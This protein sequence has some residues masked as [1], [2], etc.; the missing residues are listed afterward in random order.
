MTAANLVDSATHAP[1]WW[2]NGGRYVAGRKLGQGASAETF[3]ARE[4]TSHEEVVLKLFPPGARGA[5]LEFRHL[6][7]AAHP[8]I[9][10]VR[11]IGR[12]A[13]GRTF[14]VTDFVPGPEIDRI[15]SIASDAERRRAF[16]RAAAEL[17]D[18]LAHLHGRGVMHGDICPAN[19]RLAA[20]GRAVLLD[21]GLAGPPTPGTG[22]A[23]GTLGYAAPEALTGAR[24]AVADLFALGA[25]LFASWTGAPPFGA[26]VAAVQRMLTGRAPTLSSVRAGLPVAW[27][28]LLERLLAPD[29]RDRP[30][31]AR[32]L[33]REIGRAVAN[34]ETPTEVDLGVPYPAGDPLEGV[35]VGRA[36]EREALRR[37]LERLADGEAA[38]AVIALVGAPGS[39]RRTLVEAVARDVDVAVAAGVLPDV[40]ILRGD[41]EQIE[42]LLGGAS[43]GAGLG[44]ED[45]GR[46]LQRRLADL[47]EALERRAAARPIAVI[48]PEGPT[49]EALAAMLA[50]T[51]PSGRLLLVIPARAPVERPFAAEIALAPL[52]SPD[53]ER[54]VAQALPEGGA[55]A[56]AVAAIVT[57]SRGHAAVVGVLAR[58][59]VAAVRS[60]AG[61]GE[62]G[63]TAEALV[64]PGDDLDATLAKDFAGL[65]HDARRAAVAAALAGRQGGEL[66]DDDERA[67]AL[68][69]G[70]AAGWLA[71]AELAPPSE[72]H[73]RIALAALGDSD[74]AAVAERA[75]RLLPDGDPRRA[76]ALAAVGRVDDAVTA[77]DTLARSALERGD[78]MAAAASFD[79]IARLAP[80]RLAAR[81]H[82]VRAS[83]LGALGRYAEAKATLDL[84]EASAHTDAERLLVVERRAWLLTRTGALREA[85]SLL[86][87]TLT[88]AAAG[89]GAPTRPLAARLGRL[90]VT[91]G[92]FGDALTCLAPLLGSGGAEAPMADAI[93]AAV[94][95]HAYQGQ[96]L[97]ARALLDDDQALRSLPP[98]RRA[99]LEGLVGQLAGDAD[100][101]R[102]CY[103]RAYEAS[104]GA[105]EVHT[106]AAVALNLGG[107]LA[108]EGL[109]GEALAATERAVRTLGQLGSTAELGAALVNAA[110]LFVQLGDLPAAR[111]ALDRARSES[112]QRAT[113]VVAA[114]A[115]FVEGDL[116][117]REGR[118]EAAASA[119]ADAASRFY[120]SGQ[121]RRAV[122]ARLSQAEALALAGRT[123]EAR[124]LFDAAVG[125]LPARDGARGHSED[126][127]DSD[128]VQAELRLA[129]ASPGDEAAKLALAERA[130]RLARAQGDQERRAAAWR[131][132]ATATAMFARAGARDAADRARA[133]ARDTFEEI[134]MATPEHHRTGLDADPDA[135]WLES[136]P[137]AAATDAALAARAAATESR[138][139]RLLRINK[140]LNSELRLPR[141]LETIVDTVI[142]LTDAERGFLLLED[143]AGELNVKLARNIDQKTLETAEFELSR[144]IARRAAEGGEPIVTIDAA[145]DT[146]FKEALSVSDLHLRSVLAVPLVVKGRAV[147]T[148]YAD[149]RLRK[150]AFDDDDVKVVLDFAD[151]AAIAIENARLLSELRRRERQVEALNRRLELELAARGEE[152]TGIKQELRESREALAVRY[153]YR[154]IVGRTPRMLELFRLLDR[155]TDT[156][157]PVVIQGESGTGKELVARA[158][159]FNGARK[160]R[161]FVSENC[162][163]IPETLLES[164]LFGYQRGA[165]T[166]AERDTRGL[167]EIADGGTLFLDEVGEMSPG[168]QGKLLR[169]LQERELRRVGSE[170]TRTVD[171]RVVVATNRDLPRM[172]EEG[173]FRQDLYYR[174]AVARI[175]LPPLRERREDIPLIVEHLLAKLARNAAGEAGEGAR[176]KPLDP[177]ALARLVAYRW[178][179]NVRELENE[180]TRAYAL[181]GERIT[182]ADLAPAIA[183]SGD[184]AAAVATD[185]D[186][187]LLKPRVERLERS[188]LR[189]ALGRSANNQTKAAELL[190]LSRF[191]LQKKLKRYRFT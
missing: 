48:V 182:V 118:A 99:Y 143:D 14:V 114:L 76:A 108:D 142:E 73:R 12:T 115:A 45:A 169:V 80:E 178:P 71:S 150:G 55:P 122:S 166:G 83:A 28:R 94:L 74:V 147:G 46:A 160:D 41:V 187:L 11:D 119:Y 172:V 89:A 161:P 139:R 30:S 25:T 35:F 116:A 42:R 171:V 129:L 13:D 52:T 163:A 51:P 123:T 102:A 57:A 110:N 135:R 113:S 131:L 66:L 15:A 7:G 58:R 70:R 24:T 49:S 87:R 27:D 18:A 156:A 47:V 144:S 157:L 54:L 190:G 149:H 8:G 132:A 177:A 155:L 75:S 106:V 34:G 90:L 63:V 98:G 126:S 36:A 92:R 109:Y 191:G 164:T 104:S 127:Q 137:A 26:G 180:I 37:G 61:A 105:G 2:P 168:M 39:G 111:R 183:A 93:E 189:E 159:H 121:P 179:G 128:V 16:E 29:S 184:D 5:E 107:L 33:L 170:R 19:V 130:V 62:L 78:V 151:Q 32:Q 175:A 65:P 96:V 136:T 40:E 56:E 145:G 138:L 154:N 50:G 10:R 173:K 181:S 188:L 3:L 44:A 59:L 9:V 31:S 53:V 67:G 77:L 84:A 101:A 185:F 85:A 20:D 86:E 68:A 4:A 21:L 103:R 38:H 158:I 133:F 165:F 97:P 91:M 176:A 134:R 125:E 186:S 124:A 140:R 23:R 6:A 81:D 174:L 64:A 117:R 72:S 22:A 82:A 141:L 88:R 146:R 148:I 60:G 1:P 17:A 100:A 43:A 69:R 152:L 120:E 79:E 153:D 95:A 167:F 162:A 112:L